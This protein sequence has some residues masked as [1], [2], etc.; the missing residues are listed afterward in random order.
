MNAPTFFSWIIINDYRTSAYTYSK[1]VNLLVDVMLH[2]K[3]FICILYWSMIRSLFLQWSTH[4]Y[5]WLYS[6]NTCQ[7]NLPGNM[8]NDATWACS[9]HEYSWLHRQDFI[10]SC[11]RNYH[12]CM[13]P[14]CEDAT[15]THEIVMDW[16]FFQFMYY[17][18]TWNVHMYV[19]W[20]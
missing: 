8:Y 1:D 18:S 3:P 2:L 13:N 12:H 9:A 19:S 16:D 4:K 15:L 5:S 17:S 11:Q 7:G 14:V 10:E 6:Q 20:Y